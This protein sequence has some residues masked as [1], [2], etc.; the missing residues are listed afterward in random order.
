MTAWKSSDMFPIGNMQMIE[1]TPK[2]LA[3]HPQKPD[4]L[5]SQKLATNVFDSNSSISKILEQLDSLNPARDINKL[6]GANSDLNKK[7]A[8]ATN[9]LQDLLK[10]GGVFN[11]LNDPLYGLQETMAHLA[12]PAG[13]SKAVIAPVATQDQRTSIS[14]PKH[15]GSLIKASRVGK[16]L[17]QQQLADL[18]GVGRR[19][20]IE[21]ESGKPRLE[22]AKV[23]QVAAAAGIDIFAIKR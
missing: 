6:L 14:T 23:L 5:A 19:F 16:K 18:A 17:T 8:A 7:L 2:Q 4:A 1:K 13:Q 3:I 12:I 9:P 21:C 22:F 11:Q 20:L 15:L 10:Q